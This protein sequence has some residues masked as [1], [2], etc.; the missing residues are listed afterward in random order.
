MEKGLVSIIVPVFNAEKYLSECVNSLI[1]QTYDNIEILL[2]DDGSNDD[3]LAICKSFENKDKRIKVFS[4][5]NGGVSSARNFALQKL[6]GEYFAFV[7]SDDYVTKDYVKKMYEFAFG[8][9]LIACGV[10]R[11]CQDG[12]T[13]E[14]VE[15]NLEELENKNLRSIFFL[16]S[17]KGLTRTLG[18]V[19]RTLFRTEKFADLTFNENLCLGE[20]CDFI[21]KAILRADIIK[22]IKEK[23]Y[24]Y[25]VNTDSATHTMNDS[26]LLYKLTQSHKTNLENAFSLGDENLTA[27]INYSF[28]LRYIMNAVY[29]KDFVSQIKSDVKDNEYLF[30]ALDK[31]VYKLIKKYNFSFKAKIRNYLIFHKKWRML[32][33]MHKLQ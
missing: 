9:D 17:C 5:E 22:I 28:V 10:L 7:D 2:I 24:I 15:S 29:K 25:R 18:S 3:S 8:G 30:N 33:A 23:M 14:I 6:T 1:E 11:L 31:S 27:L 16:D 13:H 19:W 26:K 20:D 21:F 4:K 32:K 12:T